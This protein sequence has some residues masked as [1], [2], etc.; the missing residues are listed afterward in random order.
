MNNEKFF[1]YLL[2]M[3][4]VTYLVRMLP[5]VLV[6]KKITNSFV[7]SFLH[8]VPIAVLT[9]MTIPA[10]FYATQN[11]YSAVAGFLAAVVLAYFGGSLLTV[12][13]MSSAA[14]FLAE[15]TVKYIV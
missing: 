12:A 2:V 5:L 14:V 13:A 10:V 6:K 4:G 11:I 8:Y 7:L 1:I 9:V 15:L 3:A